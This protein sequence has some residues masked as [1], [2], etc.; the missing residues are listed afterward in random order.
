[1]TSPQQTAADPT[2]SAFVRA[3]AGSGKTKTLIDRT[4]RLLLGGADPAAI[5]CVTYTRAAAA[6]MQR[7]LFALLGEWSVLDND[8]LAEK[9]GVLVGRPAES[10]DEDALSRARRLFA[11]ALET[12]GGLKIQTIHGFCERLLR[13]FPIEAGVAPGFEVMDDGAGAQ[14]A[15]LARDQVAERVL[16][17]SD[18]A[19]A[20][21]YGRMSV[22]LDFEAFQ[23]M[24]AA[25][26]SERSGIAAWIDHIGGLPGLLPAVLASCGLDRLREASAIEE[27]AVLP[28]HLDPAAWFTAAGAMARG[29]EK[30]DQPRG[31][32]FRAIA[33]AAMAVDPSVEAVRELFFTQTGTMRASVATKAVDPAIL[34]WLS[35]E[36]ARLDAAFQE[37]RATKVAEDT[38]WVMVL[39]IAYLD[40]HAAARRARGALDFGDLVEKTCALLS[41]RPAAAWV[42]YKLDG[43]IDHILLDEAQD[44][45]PDQWKIIEGLTGEFFSGEGRPA[46]RPL[47]RTLFVVGDDKQSIYSFQG[48]APER[49]AIETR[50]YV[51][52]IAAS[53]QKPEEVMLSDSWRSTKQVLRFVDAVFDPVEMRLSVQSDETQITHEAKRDDGPGCVDL[54]APVEEPARVDR[55]AWDAP[56]DEVAEQSAT[57]VLAGRIAREI[58]DTVARG[59]G[60]FDKALNDGRGGRRAASFGDVLILVRRRGAMFEEVLRALKQ[61]DIPVAGADRL[62]L[63]AHIAF[64]DLLAL[65]RF[66][67]FPGDELTLAAILKSPFCGLDDDSLYALA[68]GRREKNLWRV[69]QTRA[70]ETAAWRE[71]CDFLTGVLAA[72]RTRRPFEFFGRILAQ[73][74]PDGL[75]G[76]QRL[77]ARLGAE[78]IEAIDEFLA[79]VLAAE[80]RGARDLESLTHGLGALDIIVKRDMDEARDQVRVMTT[81]GA[82]GLEAPIVI[83]PEMT[84]KPQARTGPLLKTKDGGYLWCASGKADSDA[85]AAAREDAKARLSHE[86][87]RLLY[88][89]LTR[90]RDRL[91]LCGKVRAEAKAETY[92]DWYLAAQDAL[93]RLDEPLTIRDGFRRYGQAPA[94]AARVDETRGAASPPPDWLF[95]SAPVQTAGRR[96]V[97]PSALGEEA[98]AVSVSPLASEGGLGRFRRGSLIHR[99]LQLLPDI[100]TE[101][102]PAAA[103][104]ILAREPGLSEAQRQEMANAALAVL[105]DPQFA[106]VFGPGSRAEVAI[107][108]EASGLPAGMAVSGQIDRLIVEPDRVLVVDFK[109][110]RPAPARIEDADPAYIRQMAAYVAT[111]REAFPGRGVEAALVWTDGPRLMAVPEFLVLRA[112]AELTATP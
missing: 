59:D 35:E 109:T 21:A 1:M 17:G 101:R 106:A 67:L 102:R 76:R 40:R 99:L 63:S 72:G 88:V 33:E 105:N 107:A 108:G 77:L 52:R 54:W 98:M 110:N 66:A 57:R 58:R 48:A 90:A 32:I 19:L 42:L 68:H 41:E 112:L 78:A 91:I 87:R 69:L 9:L 82:K 6:E 94:P 53:G 56:L 81:H 64:D 71:A 39:A 3:N 30:T 46:N 73:T 50:A 97:S 51:E 65:A 5:L 89:G 104:R 10:F 43:G 93:D 4:A 25:F 23:K 111:L 61:A 47:K 95:R 29:S 45:A 86:Q 60:V 83:L 37:A 70:D 7:R 14:I 34:A 20:E 15:R 100:A 103:L 2:V 75:S 13:R 24:F 8:P 12:P 28:P 16:A 80:G 22:A 27:E 36:Q 79:Q 92:G 85:T 55:T 44:T 96:F 49:L 62:A 84:W 74:G 38:L 31:R 11:L 18:P 26:E